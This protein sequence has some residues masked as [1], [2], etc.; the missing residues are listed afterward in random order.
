M[1]KLTIQ[2]ILEATNGVLISGDTNSIISSVSTDSRAISK[3]ALFVPIIGENFDG[4]DFIEKSFENGAKASFITRNHKKYEDIVKNNLK[5][6]GSLI[7]VSD[8]L[9]AL[10]K[11]AEYYRH[12]L[13][14]VIIG[15]TGSVGKTTTK[16]LLCSVLS[17]NMKVFKSPGNINGQLGT[18]LNILSID[19][20]YQA[21]V[22]EM[23]VSKI[24]EMNKLYNITRPDIGII[25]NIG[26]SHLENF[27]NIETTCYEKSQIIQK[28]NSKL[29][30]NGDIPVLSK[31]HKNNI[32]IT[33]FGINGDYKYKCDEILSQCDKTSFV[34]STPEFKDNIVIPCL[35]I[36]NVY[37]SLAAI[38][39]ALDMNMHIDD[40]KSGLLKFKNI[41]KRQEILEFTDVILIDDSYNSSP[42]S[43]KSSVSII[44]N[45]NATGTVILILGDMLELGKNSKDIHFE[46]GR[47]I[48]TEKINILITVGENSEYLSQGVKSVNQNISC[49]HCKNNSEII[50]KLEDINLIQ[51]INN[52]KNK[53]LILIKGSRSMHLE[54]VSEYIKNKY[55]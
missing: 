7:E 44:K 29:Y 23:G 30:V 45:L 41:N 24:G 13:Q 11:L 12:K 1:E 25:T 28:E 10:Q 34:L 52:I 3:D 54:E 6:P 46:T 47:H 16:E 26:V 43:V 53:N 2:E 39:V 15:I 37:N 36:H 14:V 49:F 50:E 32:N 48:A 51:D 5:S 27:K 40:I 18:P 9:E 38:C 55:K 35:G 21:A 22:L 17:E 31:L 19:N 20:S 33:K 4:H 8:T 42:D